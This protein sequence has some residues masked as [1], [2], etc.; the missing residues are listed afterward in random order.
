MERFLSLA[1]LA[2]NVNFNSAR[3]QEKEEEEEEGANRPELFDWR[4][5]SV[6]QAVLDAFQLLPEAPEEE[7]LPDEEDAT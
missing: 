1:I 5:R 6:S 2:R 3:F 7:A 4:G